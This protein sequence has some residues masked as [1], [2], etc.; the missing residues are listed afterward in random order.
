MVDAVR[1]AKAE[2]RELRPGTS[3]EL[4]S[5]KKVT[6]QFNP[7]TL[8]VTYANQLVTPEGGGGSDRSGTAARQFVGAGTTKLSLALWF[9]ATA[10]LPEGA[11]ATDD[12]RKLTEGVAY[13]ITPKAEGNQF[14]PPGIRFLWGSFQFDGLVDGM[15]ESL[16]FFSPEGRPL[17]AGV[18][19]NL[20]QQKI[21]AFAYG[22]AAAGRG[23]AFGNVAQAAGGLLGTRPLTP[24]PAG[25][26]LPQLADA[27]GL[28]DRWQEIA[29]RNGID[30]PR[31]IGTGTLID[32]GR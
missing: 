12:V 9:D 16:E 2:L 25:L 18:T 32:L 10:P 14:V 8:K 1:L 23:G 28:G 13:F 5:G 31:R 15:E 29:A 30:D 22:Q 21:T 27:A 26:G 24:T 20:S 7:E 11:P 6:V 17:R 4:P 19:L 3:E